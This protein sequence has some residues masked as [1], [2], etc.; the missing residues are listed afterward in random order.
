MARQ[1]TLKVGVHEL[2]LVVMAKCGHYCFA[3][4]LSGA[5]LRCCACKDVW[6][7]RGMCPM[8]DGLRPE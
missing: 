8:C 3:N 7:A 5:D 6:K 2:W 4:A 1:S